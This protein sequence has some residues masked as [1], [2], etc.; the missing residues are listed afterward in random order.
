MAVT[1]KVFSESV[2]IAATATTYIA[3]VVGALQTV[4]K[5]TLFNS[6]ATFVTVT[7]YMVPLA[8]TAGVTNTLMIKTLAPNETYTCPEV[9]GKSLAPGAFLQALCTTAAVVNF[10]ANG[11]VYS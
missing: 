11:K 2:T 10:A 3:A 7:I 1:P 8:G 4:E 9:V 6:A 5:C